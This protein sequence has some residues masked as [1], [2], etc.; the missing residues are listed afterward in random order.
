M[1]GVVLVATLVSI[2]AHAQTSEEVGQAVIEPNLTPFQGEREGDRALM[3]H[4]ILNRLTIWIRPR[5]GRRIY[6]PGCRSLRYG[7]ETQIAK[8]VDYI[9]IFCRK[10]R[11]PTK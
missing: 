11:Y 5:D 2:K 1:A 7:C 6:T 3:T 10:F 4:V 8:M 9:W